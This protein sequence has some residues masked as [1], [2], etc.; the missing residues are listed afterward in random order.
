MLEILKSGLPERGYLSGKDFHSSFANSI[1]PHGPEPM[2][3]ATRRNP[4]RLVLHLWG[5]LLLLLEGLPTAN[6]SKA[7]QKGATQ[8][9]QRP[10]YAV[11]NMSG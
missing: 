7:E 6:P 2:F 1:Q 9:M 11:Y 3:E 10:C 8:A 5:A 4:C